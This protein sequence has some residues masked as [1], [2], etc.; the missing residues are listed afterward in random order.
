MARSWIAAGLT[1]A[2]FA[3]AGVMTTAGRAA[4]QESDAHRFCAM[5]WA[6]DEARLHECVGR[7]IAGAQIV[8]R[9]LDWAKVSA[10]PDGE[11][12]IGMFEECRGLW[13]PDY[14]LVAECLRAG[15]LI[16]P[17]GD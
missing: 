13:A 2:A 5:Q 8:V 15:A 1:A 17:P 9:Y 4:S 12:V 10:G 3:A 14:H 6:S 11:H 7:Q 16:A